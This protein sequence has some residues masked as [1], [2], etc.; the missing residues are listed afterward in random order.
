MAD[1]LDDLSADELAIIDLKSLTPELAK[2]IVLFRKYDEGELTAR[3]YLQA[4]ASLR[5]NRPSGSVP[6]SATAKKLTGLV[7]IAA[8]AAIAFAVGL[9]VGPWASKKVYGYSS[10]EECLLDAKNRYQASACDEL[11]PRTAK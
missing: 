8:I 7:P 10:V 4:V 11:F 3:E 9:A 2:Q 5:S 1:E 6:D